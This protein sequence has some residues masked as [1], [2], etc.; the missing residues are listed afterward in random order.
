MKKLLIVSLLLCN[1]LLLAQEPLTI[2][3]I[4]STST[5]VPFS[6]IEKVPVYKGCDPSMR[7]EELKACMSY[8]I[9]NLVSMNFNTSIAND[10]GLPDG[11]VRVNVMFKIDVDGSII[12]VQARAPHPALEAEAIR[13]VNLIPRLDKPGYFKGE[14]VVVPY[15]LPI[16]F[17][18]EN[19]KK[20]KSK[21]K[22]N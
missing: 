14:P 21:T 3:E 22:R 12:D 19:S 16:L 18:V 6:I 1:G 10:L 11:T 9:T 2:K 20:R 15:S 13:V 7:T 5:E 4:D 8:A 17:K